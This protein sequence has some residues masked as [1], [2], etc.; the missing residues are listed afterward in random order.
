[1]E[2]SKPA[3]SREIF[4]VIALI[5]SMVFI[6]AAS[7]REEKAVSA[8]LLLGIKEEPAAKINSSRGLSARYLVPGGH[9]TG[10]KIFMDGVMVVGFTKVGSSQSPALEA[11][12]REGDMIK[13]VNGAKVETLEM[14]ANIVSEGGGEAMAITAERDSETISLTVYPA[15]DE[16]DGLFKIG[17]WVRDSMAGIGT[18]TFYDPESGIYGALG[19]GIND[20]DTGRLL[21][22]RSGSLMGSTVASVKKGAVG[23]PGELRGEFDLAKDSGSLEINSGSGI[24][25]RMYDDSAY[26]D[27]EP[28]KVVLRE[29]VKLGSATIL[30]NI[31]GDQVEEISVEIVKIY[32][33]NK[34]SRD[35]MIRITEENPRVLKITGGIVQGMSGSPILQNGKLIGSLTHVTI[36]DPRRGYAVFIDRMLD[37][38]AMIDVQKAVA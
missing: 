31:E 7:K 16:Y 9:T 26:R 37:E 20:V 29:E 21:P 35:M 2:Q 34:G 28:V 19:H 15:L 24:F 14:L 12:L 22:L 23:N 17:A 1:M 8:A 25:G 13:S 38:A 32:D 11:G 18:I 6:L 27:A 10:I 30:S 33:G 5:F 3:E 36:N 4:L